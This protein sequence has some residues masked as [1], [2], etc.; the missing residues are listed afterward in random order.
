VKKAVQPFGKSVT[1]SGRRPKHVKDSYAST[2]PKRGF[3]G[4]ASLDTFIPLL[5]SLASVRRALRKEFGETTGSIVAQLKAG[6][7]LSD[8]ELAAQDI[9]LDLV[10]NKSVC[11][12]S[13]DGLGSDGGIFSIN[14][15]RFGSV[16][17]DRCLRT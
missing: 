1:R 11:V 3:L 5:A 15:M 9:I 13:I 17:L 10:Q 14:I 16:F 6:Q 4:A 2:E 12:E 7:L 8:E